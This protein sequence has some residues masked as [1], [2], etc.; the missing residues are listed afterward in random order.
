MNNNEASL[1]AQIQQKDVLIQIQN[2]K[3]QQQDIDIKKLE[4]RISEKEDY[5]QELD[6]SWIC[7]TKKRTVY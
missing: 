3:I 7:E 6:K 5:I 1:K 4:K 2:T